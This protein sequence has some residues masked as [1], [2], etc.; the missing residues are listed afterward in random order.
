MCTVTDFD[1]RPRIP[2]IQDNILA[3]FDVNWS[4]YSHLC[5]REGLSMHWVPRGPGAERG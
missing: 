4:Q 1:T 2:Q 5:R 3:K